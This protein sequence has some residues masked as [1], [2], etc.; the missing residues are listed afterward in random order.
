MRS[1]GHS[2][3]SMKGLRRINSKQRRKLRARLLEKYLHACVACGT[4]GN[5]DNPLTIDHIVPVTL[6]GS[7]KI[8]NLQILCKNCADQKSLT[9]N[10][11][12]NG[13]AGKNHIQHDW[14][15]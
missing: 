8:D 14:P 15:L 11:Y 2:S 5:E 10:K 7:N 9:E 6:G 1:H 12:G 4:L 13:Q 3:S